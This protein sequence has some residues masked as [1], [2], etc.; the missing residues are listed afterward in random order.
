M[1]LTGLTPGELAFWRAKWSTKCCEVAASGNNLPA[2]RELVQHLHSENV[3]SG[4][5]L[6]VQIHGRM[7]RPAIDWTVILLG[8]ARVVDTP[9]PP[10]V[11]GGRRLPTNRRRLYRRRVAL[12]ALGNRDACSALR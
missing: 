9:R 1:T 2:T 5:D 11:L 8:I 4:N 12:S 10:Y 7:L 6:R 3:R